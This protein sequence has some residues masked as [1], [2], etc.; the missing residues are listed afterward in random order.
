MQRVQNQAFL[1]W[2]KILDHYENTF[3][4]LWTIDMKWGG[5]SRLAW[6]IFRQANIFTRI[7]RTNSNN[8]QGYESKINRWGYSG[9]KIDWMTIL[10]P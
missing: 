10:V 2:R 8:I 4:E 9:T 6:F 7:S 3:E 1:S 5:A